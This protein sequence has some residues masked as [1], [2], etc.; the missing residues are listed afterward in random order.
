[1]T[2]NISDIK[3]H[4]AYTEEWGD[5]TILIC[6]KY[7]SS[8]INNYSHTHVHVHDTLSGIKVYPTL[9]ALFSGDAQTVIE[10]DNLKELNDYLQGW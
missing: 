3:T 9:I 4:V 8:K 10:R 6:K 7:N 1:M 5:G 2:I